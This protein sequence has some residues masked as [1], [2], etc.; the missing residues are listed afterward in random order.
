MISNVVE[1]HQKLTFSMDLSILRV[2]NGQKNGQ[3]GQKW[4]EMVKSQ[5]PQIKLC[6]MWKNDAEQRIWFQIWWKLYRNS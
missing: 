2:Q 5:D 6:H 3:N 4:P 1:I